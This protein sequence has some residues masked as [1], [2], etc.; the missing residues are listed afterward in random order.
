MIQANTLQAR[1]FSK[2][3]RTKLSKSGD[4]LPGGGFPIV[5]KGDLGNAE[6]AIGRAK[7]PA[8]TK[9][10]IR[11]RA[12]ALGVKLSNKWKAA[13]KKMKGAGDLGDTEADD[14]L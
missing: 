13:G 8:A 9:A 5:N 7:N 2:K 4:A 10:H 11:K 1:D 14:P 6:R 3:Q 12:K